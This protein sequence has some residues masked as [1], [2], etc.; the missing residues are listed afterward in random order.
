VQNQD[1]T[2]VQDYIT[3][4]KCLL[5]MKGRK[6]LSRWEGQSPRHEVPVSQLKENKGKVLPHFGI[7]KEKQA[8]LNQA[9]HLEADLLA[10]SPVLTASEPAQVPSVKDVIGR[11]LAQI[12]SY[13]DLDSKQQAVALVNEDLCI[14]CGKCYMTCNDSGYQAIHFDPHSHIPTITDDCTGCTLCV[15]VCP[16]PDCITM[17]PRE[18]PY[19]PNRG[20]AMQS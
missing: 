10:A 4:L 7:Y 6:D 18:I 11:A 3:G 15:S 9:H 14:N 20:V 12:G 19:I 17:V 13:G 8:K 1:F 5:Y 16:V 2:V